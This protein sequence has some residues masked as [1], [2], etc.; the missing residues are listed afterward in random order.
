MTPTNLLDSQSWRDEVNKSLGRL[1]EAQ[2]G[3]SDDMYAI[4][5]SI[6]GNGQKGIMQRVGDLEAAENRRLGMF[7]VISVAVSAAVSYVT[8]MFG[9]KP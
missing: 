3:M 5:R 4:R 8:G 7:Y 9:H 1:E 6:E 2:K